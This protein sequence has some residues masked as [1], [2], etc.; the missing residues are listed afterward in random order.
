MDSRKSGKYKE[1][2][3]W[4][5]KA[6]NA[7]ANPSATLLEHLGDILYKL[8]DEKGALERWKEA[9]DLDGGNDKLV[10]KIADQTLYE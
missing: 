7:S 5:I 3:E 8:G 6:I 9:L 1:A 2:K 10:K 4:Q